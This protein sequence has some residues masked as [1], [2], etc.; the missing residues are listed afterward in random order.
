MADLTPLTEPQPCANPALPLVRQAY[1]PPPQRALVHEHLPLPP[2]PRKMVIH[3]EP[4]EDKTP[5]WCYVLG[6]SAGITAVLL[7]SQ[8]Y[9]QQ[10]FRAEA[11]REFPPPSGKLSRKP[12]PI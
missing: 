6:T 1:L 11:N 8:Y 2:A 12:I 5:A 10:L 3:G 9:G 4:D 7:A